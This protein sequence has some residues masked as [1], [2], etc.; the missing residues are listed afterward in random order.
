M[1]T[2]QLRL[3]LLI[4]AQVALCVALVWLYPLSAGLFKPRLG[5]AMQSGANPISLVTHLSIYAGLFTIHFV[6]LKTLRGM[7]ASAIS[8]ITPKSTSIHV[9]LKG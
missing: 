7:I 4:L 8:T 6:S 3:R 5:W 1:A 9:H 2:H